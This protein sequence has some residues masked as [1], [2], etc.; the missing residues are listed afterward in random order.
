[1]V[2]RGSHCAWIVEAWHISRQIWTE[3]SPLI[4]PWERGSIASASFHPSTRKCWWLF[5]TFAEYVLDSAVKGLIC[6]ALSLRDECRYVKWSQSCYSCFECGPSLGTQEKNNI[7]SARICHCSPFIAS[8]T[9][10]HP[11]LAPIDVIPS[12][13]SF[14]YAGWNVIFHLHSNS[15]ISSPRAYHV[16]GDVDD[17]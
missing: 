15:S 5:V 6:L 7:Y 1:M 4:P 14:R 11:L 17:M 3:G 12:T 16:R 2:R 9:S 10:R 8:M 13:N